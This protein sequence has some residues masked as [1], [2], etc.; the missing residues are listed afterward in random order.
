MRVA[1]Q[2]PFSFRTSLIDYGKDTLRYEVRHVQVQVVR[3]QVPD[4]TQEERS[5]DDRHRGKREIK[6]EHGRAADSP[7]RIKL[8]MVQAPSLLIIIGH[9]DGHRRA[10]FFQGFFGVHA[11]LQ[12]LIR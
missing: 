4:R 11:D 9:P 5:D 3:R 10:D 1:L 6:D 7:T 2:N 12:V 8:F